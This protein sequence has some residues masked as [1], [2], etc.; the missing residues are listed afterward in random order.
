MPVD[1]SFLFL[2]GAASS[3]TV[4]KTMA[5]VF[6]QGD[7][8][9]LDLQVD[10]GSDFKA[11]KIQWEAYFSLSG[12]VDQT[13][14]KQVQALTLSLSR[15]TLTIV[16][17]LGLTHSAKAPRR[18]SPPS[19]H[20]STGKSTSPWNDVPLDLVYNKKAKCSTIS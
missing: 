6:R 14:E 16:E 4:N 3:R 13:A 9:K 7:L 17:N 5:F 11:W 19:K 20:T 1:L 18:L 15:E 10:R 12:L 8:P 2:H